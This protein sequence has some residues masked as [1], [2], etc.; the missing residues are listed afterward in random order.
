M[1]KGSPEI[2]CHCCFIEVC[3]NLYS[4]Y[5]FVDS[6]VVSSM[7][8]VFHYQSRF[9]VFILPLTPVDVDSLPQLSS[10][11]YQSPSHSQLSDGRSKLCSGCGFMPNSS[12][13]GQ[14]S[15]GRSVSV[16]PSTGFHLCKTFIHSRDVM[17]NTLDYAV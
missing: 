1:P 15:V 17:L 16:Y 4:S 2:K 14:R 5:Y 8:P 10:S 3:T 9:Y 12:V 6:I 13:H 11:T 7:C